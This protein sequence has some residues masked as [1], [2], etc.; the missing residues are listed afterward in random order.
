MEKYAS[1]MTLTLNLIVLKLSSNLEPCLIIEDYYFP[2]HLIV[3][4][5]Y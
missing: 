3:G 2:K 4:M 1:E 5:N